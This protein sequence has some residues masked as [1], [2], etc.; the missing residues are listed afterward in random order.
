MNKIKSLFAII[1]VAAVA[2]FTVG[3]YNFGVSMGTVYQM[4]GPVNV[5][6]IGPVY[7]KCTKGEPV[8]QALLRAAEQKGGNGIANVMVDVEISE[9]A[10]FGSALAVRYTSA[11]GVA[12]KPSSEPVTILNTLPHSN[13]A[14]VLE[15][16]SP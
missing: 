14:G 1:C 16:Y 9:N 8:Y 6:V 2:T 7:V 4:D 5:E 11:S 13:Q 10:R 12:I 15:T 3:C